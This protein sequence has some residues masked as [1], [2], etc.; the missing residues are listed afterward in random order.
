M[1][2]DICLLLSLLSGLSLA[3]TALGPAAAKRLLQNNQQ[4]PASS[5]AGV[6][7][8]SVDGTEV[9]DGA[10]TATPKTD[11]N[12]NPVTPSGR[13]NDHAG[14]K[15]PGA[16]NDCG[17]SSFVTVTIADPDNRPTVEDTLEMVKKVVVGSHEWVVPTTGREILRYKSVGFFATAKGR[18][19]AIG[20]DDIGDLGYDSATKYAQ[21]GYVSTKG[22]YKQYVSE[23][24]AMACDDPKHDEHVAVDVDWTIGPPNR[25]GKKKD[26]D[27]TDLEEGPPDTSKEA[28]SPRSG[29]GSKLI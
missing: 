3:G 8:M 17:S 18:P 28:V 2:L 15:R 1:R 10:K 20:N 5:P 4:Q 9:T 11:E 26:D 12:G 7:A 13:V 22:S 16:K 14:R 29:S 21:Q 23:A 6:S 19:A 25:K 24:G 27:E